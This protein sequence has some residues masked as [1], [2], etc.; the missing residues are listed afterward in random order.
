MFEN[1]DAI[2][3]DKFYNSRILS[4]YIKLFR[5]KYPHVDISDL[6]SFAQIEQTA[7]DD[8]FEWFTQE[9]IDK[10]FERLF[11]YFENPYDIAREA[12]R[13]IY[14]DKGLGLWKKFTLK[15]FG[16]GNA[17]KNIGW[18][19]RAITRSCTFSSRELASNKYEVKV[20]FKVKE[21]PHQ[22]FTRLGILEAAPRMYS[23]KMARVESSTQG[24]T[25]TYIIAWDAAKSELV[26]KFMLR[27][28]LAAPISILAMLLAV[29]STAAIYSTILFVFIFLS[30]MAIQLKLRCLELT[31]LYE[32]YEQ[33]AETIIQSY[34]EDYEQ[35][36][37][38][39]RIGRIVLRS[40][41]AESFLPAVSD[42][43][44]SMNYTKVS[45]FVSAYDD[46]C[47]VQKFNDGYTQQLSGFRITVEAV[48]KLKPLLAPPTVIADFADLEKNL[49]IGLSSGFTTADFPLVFVPI[50][51]DAASLG[52]FFVTPEKSLL[53]FVKKKLDF[54]VGV[55]SHI[56]LGLHKQQA[57][58]DIAESDRVKSNFISTA[59]HE[60]KTPIQVMMMGLSEIEQG[61]DIAENILSL[62]AVVSK[63][64]EY[65]DNLLS[66]Q[67]IENKAYSLDLHPF[68]PNEVFEKLKDEMHNTAKA[69]SHQVRFVGFS[70]NRPTI[71]GDLTRLS[72]V[73]MNLF[74]NSCKFTP[75][76]GMIVVAYDH[77]ATEHRITVLDNGIGISKT[78]IDKVFIKFYQAA[79]AID[80]FS[81]FGLGLSISKEIVALH[82]GYIS[83]ISPLLINKHGLELDHIRIG[84]SMTVHLPRK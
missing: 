68:T 57:F 37:I 30:L 31:H 14:S 53:P 61:G 52:F 63:M 7:I 73:L 77:D 10:F 80:G 8:P 50:V 25:T 71:L 84:T 41:S 49:P 35:V 74:G 5:D 38:L 62:K 69:F 83:V 6:L 17:Y 81:G 47:I 65:V 42:T 18:Y 20:T 45:F 75:K 15:L 24:D 4:Y 43:L 40:N 67:R 1:A 51:S 27:F 22:A 44:R 64:K 79:G 11:K 19:A 76:A 78:D 16:V 46:E 55:A 56:A 3:T 70:S 23:D 2:G 60:L 59:S 36:N 33:S 72:V 39:N 32:N 13:Y 48:A 58:H 9:Q 12:G 34:I 26:E 66:L 82:N 54:L 29:N 28:S 21:S